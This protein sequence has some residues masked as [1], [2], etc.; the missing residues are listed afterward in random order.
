MMNSLKF[1]S[2]VVPL[3]LALSGCIIKA[4]PDPAGPP[5]PGYQEP[6]QQGQ[7]VQNDPNAQPAQPA[8][9]GNH[10]GAVANHTPGCEFPANHCLPDDVYI[11]ANHEFKKGYVYAFAG[12]MM[13][14]PGSSGEATFLNLK[15][16]TQEA[17]MNY[18]RT[19]PSNP[20]E[21][22]VGQ[23]VAM[24]HHRDGGVYVAPETTDKAVSGTWWI[25]RIVSTV[26]LSQGSVIVAGGHIVSAGNLRL[27]EGDTSQTA[28]VGGAEDQH[29]LRDG[30]WIVANNA[31]GKRKYVYASVAA[32]VQTPSAQT[33]NEGH[34]LRLKDGAYV[35]TRE[36]WQTRPATQ[37]DLQ[38]GVIVFMAHHREKG[39]YVRFTERHKS[40]AGTWW[41]SRVTDTSELY[42]GTVT[43][44]GGHRVAV[45]NLRVP[46]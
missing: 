42:R 27:L 36:A 9:P 35:W 15:K 20:A 39:T 14:Q 12:R 33:K 28:S 7:Y 5:P 6:G 13:G 41:V 3:A 29:F 31:L 10:G 40:V 43:V 30:H 34:Y 22:A 17:K 1:V 45:D 26:G 4:A 21:L 25:S 37:A 2:C 16:G 44:A 24:F 23:L 38:P 8:Q 18:Y 46:R 19:R 32:A 11:V